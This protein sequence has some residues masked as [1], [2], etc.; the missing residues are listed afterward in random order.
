[1]S[2]VLLNTA[3]FPPVQYL[4]R[5][6]K[7]DRVII[8]QQD[9][10]GKQSYRNRCE[11]LTANGR[12][13]LVVP[14]CRATT[15]RLL[16]RDARVDYSTG[17]QKV[18]LKSIESA[19]RNSPF[20]DYYMDDFLPFFQREERFLIDL[21]AKIL[22]R[23]LG[24]LGTRRPL[25]L[26]DDYLQAPPPGTLDLRDVIHPK[27]SRRPREDAYSFLAYHQTFSDRFPFTPALSALD[28]LFNTGPTAPS[29]L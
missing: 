5:A 21:N 1:M 2:T 10:Y 16:T 29:Y 25:L 9:H 12:Q 11:I 14:V 24:C 27:I 23:L 20:Y 15:G 19:Y 3:Y 26:T 6:W 7:A 17:W 22:E 4:A 8:E 18:H 13:T 28:L